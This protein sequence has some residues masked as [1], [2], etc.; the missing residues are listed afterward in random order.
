[1]ARVPAHSKT[2]SIVSETPGYRPL[3]R[4]VYDIVVRRVAQGDWRPGEALPSEQSLARELGVSQGTMRKVLDALTAEKVLDRRQG[5]GT[6]IAQNTQERTQFRFFRL[7]RPGGRRLTPALG[8]ESA[9]VRAARAI[10]R[11]RLELPRDA[12][13]VEILRMRLIEGTPA[14]REQILLPASVFPGIEKQTPLPNSL[15]TL[16]Q[17]AFGVTIVATHEELTAALAD[18]EDHEQLGVA[19]GSPILV[20]DRLAVG[21]TNRKV[22]WRMTRVS[23]S[24]LVYAVT[25]T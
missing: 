10:E 8:T 14:I 15:Y 5:K 1:M 3:Y 12:R 17:S 16:Y 24:N 2:G 23:S 21:L 7:A 13:I 19:A 4:Q 11:E 25:L 6:F 22:E 20:I 18:A 9:R